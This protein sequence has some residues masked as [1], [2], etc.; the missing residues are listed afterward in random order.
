MNIVRFKKIPEWFEKMVKDFDDSIL[1]FWFW[2]LTI[3][4]GTDIVKFYARKYVSEIKEDI[5]AIA[6]KIKK[7]SAVV[8]SKISR[9][10]LFKRIEIE[11]AD[12]RIFFNRVVKVTRKGAVYES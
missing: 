5:F 9:R 2:R 7:E 11:L 10:K 4:E 12:I 3:E 6:E 1:D 8:Q